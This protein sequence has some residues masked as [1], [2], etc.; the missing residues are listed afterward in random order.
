M[1]TS[2]KTCKDCGESLPLSQFYKHSKMADGHLNHCKDCKADY[3]RLRANANRK[4]VRQVLE[5]SYCE[6]CG[7]DDIRVLEFDHI[8]PSKKIDAV[9][10]MVAK[11]RNQKELIDELSKCRVLCANCHRIHTFEQQHIGGTY[12][13]VKKNTVLKETT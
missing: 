4:I 3:Q 8:D 13:S 5:E 10:N 2:L 9:G 12:R 11:G 6:E 7:I 1:T